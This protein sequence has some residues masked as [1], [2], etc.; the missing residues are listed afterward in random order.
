MIIVYSDIP[1]LFA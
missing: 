1:K